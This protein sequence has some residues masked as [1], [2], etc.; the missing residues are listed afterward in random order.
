[1]TLSGEVQPVEPAPRRRGGIRR[2]GNGWQ[3]RVSSGTD[4][5]T[6]DRIVL[7]ETVP[8]APAKTK[9]ARERVEREARKEADKVLTRLQAEADS[10][11]VART[12]A[13]L[14][15]LLDRWLPQHEVDPTTRMNYESQIRNYITPNLGDVPLLLLARDASERLE[16]FYARLRR[17]RQ[18]CSGRPF[19]EKHEIND[20]HDC[21]TERCRAHVCKP[22]AASSIRQIHAI[23]S[24]ALSAAVRW[25]WIAY[26][27]M[28]AV[29]PPAKKRPQPKPPSSE[30]MARIVEEAWKA[31]NEW[32]LYVWLSAVTGARRGEVIALQWDDVN[33]ANGVV[34][35]DENYVRAADGM[36]VKDTKTHQMRRVSVDAPTVELLGRHKNDCAHQLSLL[37]LP[38]NEQTWLFSAKPDLSKPRDPSAVTRRYSRLAQ[39]LGVATQLKELRHYSATELLTAGVDLRTVAGRLGHGDGTTTLRHYAAWVGAADEAAA[40]TIGASMPPLQVQANGSGS[41]SGGGRPESPPADPD[42][43]FLSS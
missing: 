32:G 12:R 21:A 8:I 16:A 34:R 22:Y 26:N 27:P 40:R 15:A 11:K 6:G 14:G 37:G 29:K 2:H 17:C 20:P 18:L 28:P 9:A 10:L 35:L 24:G 7:Y 42:L 4:P 41:G 1:M 30:Q 5:S 36:I 39:K 43:G 31:S 38:L 33:L 23:L 3:V 19:I 25:G 13:T